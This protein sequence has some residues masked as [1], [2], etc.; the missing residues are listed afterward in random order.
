MVTSNPAA[1]AR[2]RLQLAAQVVGAVF[3]LVGI[4]G[5][6]PG[7]TSNFGALGMAGHTS[8]ALLLGVFQVSV[9]HNIVHLLFGV[10]GLLLARTPAQAKSFLLYGG[11]IYLILWLYGLIINL[12][13]PANFVPVNTADNWLHFLLG[14]GMVALALLLSRE[15]VR[16]PRTARR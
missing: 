8:G 10:A 4:L 9:L 13:S 15:G 2:S 16:T 1:G 6:I 14:A 11:I 12:N 7:I 5:F 3:L